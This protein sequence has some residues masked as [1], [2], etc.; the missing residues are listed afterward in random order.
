MILIKQL[1]D[2]N[3]GMFLYNEVNLKII[4]TNNK[5]LI[6]LNFYLLIFSIL[7][8][9]KINLNNFHIKNRNQDSFGSIYSHLKV[10][11]NMK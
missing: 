4:I 5:Y 2:S 7:F 8:L 9:F 3:Y 1:F 6:N 10:L 11:L